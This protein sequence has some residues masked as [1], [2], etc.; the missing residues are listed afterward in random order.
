MYEYSTRRSAYILLNVHSATV[1][2]RA[3]LSPEGGRGSTNLGNGLLLMKRMT[4]RFS[5]LRERSLVMLSRGTGPSARARGE[6]LSVSASEG[7]LERVSIPGEAGRA[8]KMRTARDPRAL[9]RVVDGDAR[10]GVHVQQPVQQV[11]AFC[12]PTSKITSTSMFIKKHN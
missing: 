5:S 9:Q 8:G 7:L 3:V 1:T 12:A 6:P 10:V 11:D 4:A 2:R